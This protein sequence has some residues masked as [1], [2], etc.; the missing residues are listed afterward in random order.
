MHIAC[1]DFEGVL[2][3]EIW[4]GLAER[5]GIEA[6]RATTREIP[7]Y[8]DLMRMRLRVMNEHGLRFADVR[9]AG[10][11]LEPLPGAREFLDWLREEYQVAI[12]SDTFYE[13]AMPLIKKL[14]SPTLLCHRLDVTADG[15]LSGYRLRQPDPKRSAV[16]GFHSMQYKVVATGDSYNDIPML[17]EADLSWFFQP[18]AN[19]ARDYPQIPVARNYAELRSA[20]ESAK[21][22]LG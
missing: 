3:P 19:V 5:T 1:L 22:T 7:D 8:D 6:L 11:A 13:V 2:V 17:E 12:V 14:G 10:E 18:P 4:V 21:Q 9:A 15:R 16:R 20:F